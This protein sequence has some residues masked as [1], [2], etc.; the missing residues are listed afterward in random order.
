[1]LHF[2][3]PQPFN[4]TETVSSTEVRQIG[5]LLVG[6]V[7]GWA[8]MLG[9]FAA[10]TVAGGWGLIVALPAMTALSAFAARYN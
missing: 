2:E 9:V 6:T 3:A 7:A 1:M 10:V 5:G 4:H 8:A